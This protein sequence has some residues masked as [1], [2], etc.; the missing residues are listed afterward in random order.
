MAHPNNVNTASILGM[1]YDWTQ[2][3]NPESGPYTIVAKQV[4]SSA[5]VSRGNRKVSGHYVSGGMFLSVLERMEH[6]PSSSITV[7][8]PLWGKAYTGQFAAVFYGG[9]PAPGNWS[10]RVTDGTWADQLYAR[11]A[12]AIGRMRPD[13]PDFSLTTSVYE[14]K[15]LGPQL[16]EA[17]SDILKKMAGHRLKRSRRGSELSRAGQYYLAAQ[18]GYIPLIRDIRNYV[19]AQRGA[20]KRLDQLIRDAGKPVRRS[21]TLRDA[22][23]DSWTTT[24]EGQDWY[25]A[26]WL[27]PQFVTQC[28]SDAHGNLRRRT[29][30]SME[31]RS[32]AMAKFRYLLPPGPRTVE[33]KKAMIRRIMG[34]IITPRE[35]YNIMPWSWLADYFTGLGDF[36]NATSGGVADNLV[37]DYGYIMRTE[38]WISSV[39]TTQSFQGSLTGSNPKR[40]T[41]SYKHSKT[42]KGRG[43][44]SPFGWGIKQE[45]LS[46][47]QVS[48]LG[49]L[50]LSRLP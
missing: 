26:G 12:E 20:Q 23:G 38:S 43:V 41:A 5:F 4:K 35:L 31:A 11:G 17:L 30:D 1:G 22:N 44:A 46:A 18:F 50:G 36:I 48:I 6:S 45:S 33:W 49:A 47:H 7:Y 37:I 8:R 19:N 3:G 40:V 42:V 13:L 29:T 9:S 21:T 27:S 2:P 25:Y 10:S 14:L 16:K 34:G 32:W 24:S 28:Y 15:D 39:E